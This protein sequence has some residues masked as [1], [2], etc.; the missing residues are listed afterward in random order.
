MRKMTKKLIR[1]GRYAADV[2][3]EL[4]YDDTEWSPYISP[5]DVQKLEATRDALQRGD[6]AEAAK[7]GRVFELTPL[8]AE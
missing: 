7:Y 6:L 2:D 1:E 8:A 5:S 4:I 3:I